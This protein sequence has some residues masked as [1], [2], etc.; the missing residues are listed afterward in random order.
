MSTEPTLLCWFAHSLKIKS[1]VPNVW[2]RLLAVFCMS[3]SSTEFIQQFFFKIVTPPGLL[4]GP[5]LGP[6]DGSQR[7]L[8]PPIRATVPGA[9]EGEG[10]R[11]GFSPGG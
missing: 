9:E 7:W 2:R 5:G 6:S 3:V 1:P 11:D 10:G 8:S 4:P